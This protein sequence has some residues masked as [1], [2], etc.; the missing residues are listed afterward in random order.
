MVSPNGTGE[1]ADRP[2]LEV[3]RVR[4][5]FSGLMALVD[6]SLQVWPGQI[7]GLIGPNGAGKTTLF[8]LI[9]G[10]LRPTAGDIRFQGRSIVGL[11]PYRIVAL[12]IARTFQNVRLFPGM[13]VLEHVLVGAHRIGRSGLLGAIFQTPRMRAE[14]A[15][16]R[17]RAWALLERVGLAEWADRPAE[18]LPLGLQRVLEVAR[19][20]ASS[21]RLLLL[22]EPGAGL[23][24]SEKARLAAL[25]QEVRRAGVTVLLVE[26]DMGLVMGLADEIAVLDYGVLIAEGPPEAIRRDPRVIAAYLGAD[27][28]ADAA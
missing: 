15:R 4:K 21:P 20:L 5:A 13:T 12:G 1:R 16:L 22:D 23:N 7:K 24:P 25:I 6:V 11:P 9:A 28:V 17:E 18:S 26:H 14:E 3:I 8:N 27:E 10:L 2:L 19:A